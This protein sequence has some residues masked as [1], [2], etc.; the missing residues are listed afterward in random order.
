VPGLQKQELLND[1]EQEDDHRSPRVLEVL[2]YLPEAY[3]SQGNEV[4]Q[5]LAVRFQL[6]AKS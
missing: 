4:K 6:L 5:P 3:G 1:E 2:Q